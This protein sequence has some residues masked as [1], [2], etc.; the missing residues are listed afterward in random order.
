MPAHSIAL[1]SS[2]SEHIALQVDFHQKTGIQ[3][4]WKCDFQNLAKSRVMQEE[5]ENSVSLV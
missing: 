2:N 1:D 4:S 5:K 3:W